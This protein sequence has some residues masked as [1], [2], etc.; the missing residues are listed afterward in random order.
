MKAVDTLFSLYPNALPSCR[1][2]EPFPMRFDILF[3][4]PCKKGL[5]SQVFS[6]KFHSINSSTTKPLN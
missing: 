1:V 6:F 2:F 3:Y 4:L 5:K